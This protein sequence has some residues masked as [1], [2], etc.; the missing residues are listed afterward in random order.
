MCNHKTAPWPS[1]ESYQIKFWLKDNYLFT[2]HEK[3]QFKNPDNTVTPHM[4]ICHN[5]MSQLLHSY[6]LIPLHWRGERTQ[7][8]S[9]SC[10]FASL[11]TS[12]SSVLSCELISQNVSELP[13]TISRPGDAPGGNSQ[14]T[15]V[16]AQTFSNRC[17]IKE[18]SSLL[19]F[20][21]VA[22]R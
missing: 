10:L 14:H 4:T 6:W 18:Q 7:K 11:V 20:E 22:P 5:H 21:A 17:Q 3:N 19:P 13:N 15:G 9:P 12:G 8:T 16:L 2:Q 1:N